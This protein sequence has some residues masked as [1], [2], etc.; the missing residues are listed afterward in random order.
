MRRCKRWAHKPF[1]SNPDSEIDPTN[2][3]GTLAMSGHGDLR[4]REVVLTLQ[5][6]DGLFQ[7]VDELHMCDEQLSRAAAATLVSVNPE[8]DSMRVD[9]YVLFAGSVRALLPSFSEGAARVRDS[10]SFFLFRPPF[11]SCNQIFVHCELDCVQFH[12]LVA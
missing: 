7:Y 11:S 5:K 2:R 8:R 4:K 10:A 9:V 12:E 3:H 1:G 6:C